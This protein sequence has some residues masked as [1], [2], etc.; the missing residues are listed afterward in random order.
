MSD[1]HLHCV[2]FQYVKNNDIKGI[3]L[4]NNKEIERGFEHCC[5]NIVLKP[6]EIL[7]YFLKH[8]NY[9][10]NW[11]DASNKSLGY[12]EKV[13]FNNYPYYNNEKEKNDND[14]S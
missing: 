5:E 8:E 14:N 12:L 13:G 11:S 1:R 3:C 7:T 10:E 9:C 4:L 6:S 2:Y